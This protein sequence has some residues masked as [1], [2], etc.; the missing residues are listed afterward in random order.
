MQEINFDVLLF[1]MNK[2]HC[3]SNVTQVHLFYV[4]FW[5]KTFNR[6]L[7]FDEAGK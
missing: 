3:L 7:S 1:E 4:K 6:I 5:Q 2:N